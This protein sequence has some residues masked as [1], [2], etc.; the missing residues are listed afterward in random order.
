VCIYK[1]LISSYRN[2]GLEEELRTYKVYMRDTVIQ[3][4]KQVPPCIG[5]IYELTLY[6]CS[7]YFIPV[8]QI[9]AMQGQLASYSLNGLHIN[10]NDSDH[11]SNH[12]PSRQP[13]RPPEARTHV[14]NP[15]HEKVSP[16]AGDEE[17]LSEHLLQK[18][19]ALQD[20]QRQHSSNKD[21]PRPPPAQRNGSSSI[22]GLASRG[23]GEGSRGGRRDSRAILGRQEREDSKQGSSVDHILPN[24]H[25]GKY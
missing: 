6:L 25:H 19:L 3:Y 23:G 4:K 20:G 8:H 15:P 2:A 16:H 22:N 13:A 1:T 11:I 24:I 18:Y 5:I 17:G 9:K 21:A 10:Q 12:G 14:P 7:F